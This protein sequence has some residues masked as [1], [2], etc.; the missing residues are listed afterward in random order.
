M[1]TRLFTPMNG[2]DSGGVQ[3]TMTGVSDTSDIFL[4]SGLS[5][6]TWS[7]EVT[8]YDGTDYGSMVV[9]R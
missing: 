5:E 1:E 2:R 9:T 8:P 6:D 7:C 4:A 3:Q